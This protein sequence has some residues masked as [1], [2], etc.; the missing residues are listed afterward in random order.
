MIRVWS[1]RFSGMFSAGGGVHCSAPNR[2]QRGDVPVS[3]GDGGKAGQ[4]VDREHRSQ[5]Q[6]VI[7]TGMPRIHAEEIPGRQIETKSL[8]TA[9]AMARPLE[10]PDVRVGNV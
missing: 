6:P 7:P 2:E 9:A 8:S 10:V 4:N 1:L 3:D 5:R